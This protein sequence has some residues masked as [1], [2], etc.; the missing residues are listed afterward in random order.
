M[1]VPSVVV[2]V[3]D[4]V[5]SVVDEVESVVD[6]VESVV[7]EVEAV[8]DEVESVDELEVESVVVSF[9]VVELVD[10]V[11]VDAVVVASVS[12]SPLS[13][14]AQAVSDALTRRQA[15]VRRLVFFIDSILRVM[16]SKYTQTKGGLKVPARSLLGNRVAWI[17]F[18][19]CGHSRDRTNSKCNA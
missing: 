6:E 19:V 4:E 13:S 2:S 11:L 17:V 3:V 18:G 9:A 15:R 7:D 12:E 16:V 5:E 14:P 10:E 8:V 1:V